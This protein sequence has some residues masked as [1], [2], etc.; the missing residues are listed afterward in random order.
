M[1]R[2][3]KNRAQAQAEL[4]PVVEHPVY[5][6]IKAIEAEAYVEP[7]DREE[8]AAIAEIEAQIALPK[9]VVLPKYKVR[10]KERAQAAGLKGKAAKRS[11]WD[12]LAQELA[13]AC[14]TPKGKL[15]LDEFEALMAANGVDTAKWPNRS[16][17][18]EGRLRMTARL[19]LQR[20]VAE[21]G[22]LKFADGEWKEAPAEFV[23][24]H[25]N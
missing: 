12:W 18:W 14:L 24:K 5:D 22:I 17:G 4:A 19:A 11:N 23:E 16:P 6:T 20:I 3:R 25:R 13:A 7:V 8:Q 21:T 9:S 1:A 10:Y 2:N 15:K